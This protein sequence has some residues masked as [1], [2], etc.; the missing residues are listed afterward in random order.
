MGLGSYKQWAWEVTS[1]FQM[2]AESSN[3]TDAQR[4]ASVRQIKGGPSSLA[5]PK[6]ELQGVSMR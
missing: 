5:H 3:N 6:I 2:T 1:N 4:Y